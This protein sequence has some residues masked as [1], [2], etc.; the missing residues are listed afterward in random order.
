MT[1]TNFTISFN[2]PTTQARLGE[3]KLLHGAVQTPIFLPVGTQATVR[4]LTPEDLEQMHIK[5][6]LCNAYHLYLRPGVEIVEKAGGLHKF[7]QWKRPILTDS[8]G[9]QIFSLSSFHSIT[10]EGISFKSHIDGSQ[11]YITPET[12][13]DIQEKLGADIIMALDVCPESTAKKEHI[14]HAMEYTARW[15]RRCRE[16]KK[17]NGQLLFGIIQGGTYPELRLKST[18]QIVSLDF[19]GYAIGGLSL[20]ES[21]EAMWSTIDYTVPHM[22]ADKPRYLMGVGSPE[23]IVEGISRGIDIFDCALP[24]RVAR[25]GALFTRKGRKNLKRTLYRDNLGPVE[26]GCACY[27]C[28]NFTSAYLH[29]LFKCEELLAYRLATIHNLYFMNQLVLDI[30]EAVRRGEYGKFRQE[31]LSGYQTTDEERRIDQKLRGLETKK[32][33]DSTDFQ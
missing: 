1:G 3:L 18:E 30:R 7:M 23:D 24:T 10:E 20:G 12:A 17:D 29:H 31:F 5:M 16:A 4:S 14:I 6:I 13:V 19:P 21:K 32:E 9:Y 27:T 2:C 22:P 25:N 11:R 26:E 33:R 15:A 28:A 8:G